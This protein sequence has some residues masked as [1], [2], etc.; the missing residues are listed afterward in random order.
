MSSKIFSNLQAMKEYSQLTEEERLALYNNFL[1]EPDSFYEKA[2]NDQLRKALLSSYK[3]RFLTMT[4]LMKINF[5]LSNAKI[6]HKPFTPA[7]KD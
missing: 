1:Q 2:E 5:M 7:N 4:R 6:T 3:E